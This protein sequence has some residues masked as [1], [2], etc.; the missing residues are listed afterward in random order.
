MQSRKCAYFSSAIVDSHGHPMNN[1]V[2]CASLAKVATVALLISLFTNLAWAQHTKKILVEIEPDGFYPRTVYANVG[3]TIVFFNRDSHS[4]TITEASHRFDS[5]TLPP[6]QAW[7]M[8]TLRRGRRIF[9]SR[10]DHSFKV[11]VETNG[12]PGDGEGRVHAKAQ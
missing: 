3:D 7:M 10:F 5:G 2:R 11:I 9:Y 12:L 8:G 4:H 6:S 1:N